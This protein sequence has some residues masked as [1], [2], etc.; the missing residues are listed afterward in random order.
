MSRDRFGTAHQV[1]DQPRIAELAELLEFGNRFHHDTNP[2]AAQ[3]QV[4]DA[5]L[6]GMI[7]RVR[8]FVGL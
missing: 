4:T 2:R 5:E 6:Q 3:E 7:V 1:I 8:Q